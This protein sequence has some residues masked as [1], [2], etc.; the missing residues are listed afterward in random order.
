VI[1]CL[2]KCTLN[3]WKLIQCSD[4]IFVLYFKRFNVIR[5]FASY[6]CNRASGRATLMLPQGKYY[7]SP[8]RI[9]NKIRKSSPSRALVILNSSDRKAYLLWLSQVRASFTFTNNCLVIY[10]LPWD[11]HRHEKGEEFNPRTVMWTIASNRNF[12]AG[13]WKMHSTFN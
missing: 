3:V 8:W 12:D 13:C 9:T 6:F 11:I 5:N 7:C 2:L 4:H 10:L 1:T